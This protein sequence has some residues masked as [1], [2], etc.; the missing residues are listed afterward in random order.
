M[1]NFDDVTKENIKEHWQQIFDH[2]YR[3]LIIG[4][5]GSRKT[6]SLFNL[7]NQ[8]PDIDKFYLY[9]KDPYEAKYQFLVNKWESTGSKHLN[10]SKAFNAYKNIEQYN[11]NKKRKILTVFDN[12]I[13]EMLSNKKLNSILTESFIRGRKL[14][15]SLVF[16]TQSYF[17]VPKDVILN[18]TNFLL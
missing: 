18:T 12:M 17:K 8:Q 9:A 13:A 14:N 10:D 11:L 15:I 4:G 5:S 3:I 2:S 16:I 1:I 7:V 6:N